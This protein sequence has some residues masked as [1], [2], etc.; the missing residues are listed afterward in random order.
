MET[1]RQFFAE[2]LPASLYPWLIEQN[3]WIGIVF[4]LFA[5]F[6][7]R[8]RLV[9]GDRGLGWTGDNCSDS[10]CGGDSGCD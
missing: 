6:V 2:H 8:H 5:A 3:G 1:V 4:A 9:P 7:F 10:D